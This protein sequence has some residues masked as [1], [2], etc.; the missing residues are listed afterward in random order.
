LLRGKSDNTLSQF[1]PRREIENT[2][3]NISRAAAV[4]HSG[5]PNKFVFQDVAFKHA[6]HV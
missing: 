2:R 1:S 4:P 5:E 6:S 3:K